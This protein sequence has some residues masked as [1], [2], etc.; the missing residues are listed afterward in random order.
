MKFINILTES[1]NVALDYKDEPTPHDTT[2][3]S[4]YFKAR[5][6]KKDLT[7]YL[8]TGERDIDTITSIIDKNAK[9]SHFKFEKSINFNGADWMKFKGGGMVLWVTPNYN[10]K[11]ILRN[12]AL[13]FPKGTIFVEHWGATMSLYDFWRVESYGNA[14]V[15]LSKLKRDIKGDLVKPTDQA[16]DTQKYRLNCRA[17]DDRCYV[18]LGYKQFLFLTKENVYDSKREYI[19]DTY[20]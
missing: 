11:D 17:G 14:T 19:Q 16:E 15:V 1:V 6:L 13:M 2:I 9:K 18:N 20:D 10:N 7:A 3:L 4:F 8:S 5:E 12:L